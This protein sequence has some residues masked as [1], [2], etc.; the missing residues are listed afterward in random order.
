[1]AKTYILA[2]LLCLLAPVQSA[3]GQVLSELSL[4]PNGANERAE[5][6]QWIGLVKITIDYHSPNVHG[7][8]G[9]DRTGQIWGELVP[10]GF[11]DQGLGPSRATPWRAGANETTTIS[12]SHD[13]KIEGKELK[14][15]TYGLFLELE[16]DGPWMWIFSHNSTGWGSF[17][18]DPKDDALRVPVNPESAALY[19]IPHLWI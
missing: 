9:A 14:A 19:R 13:V 11:F 3:H 2:L 5:V 18:Y 6:S 16:K 7:G 10:Y 1:M 12:F 4:P 15:G 8:T 17:Q